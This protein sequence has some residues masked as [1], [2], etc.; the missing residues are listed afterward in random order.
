MNT[1]WMKLAF[2]A[3][4]IYDGIFAL[5]FLFLGPLIHDYFGIERPN[6]LGPA[7][8][9]LSLERLSMFLRYKPGG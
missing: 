9:G 5:A 3:S 7:M 8:S 2:G 1:K 6:H 4:P